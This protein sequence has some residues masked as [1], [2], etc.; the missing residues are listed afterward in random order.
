MSAFG[1]PREPLFIGEARDPLLKVADARKEL[2]AAQAAWNTFREGGGIT[3]RHEVDEVAQR[4]LALPYLEC[5]DSLGEL[6]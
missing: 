1:T 6:S 3:I 2:R 4:L 5:V